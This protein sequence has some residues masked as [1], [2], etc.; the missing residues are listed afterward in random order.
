MKINVTKNSK[1][2]MA[3]SEYLIVLA[4]VA[5]GCICIFGLFGKQIKYTTARAA[6][7]LSG[8]TAVAGNDALKDSDAAAAKKTGMVD[9]NNAGN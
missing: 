7:T 4:V 3:M 9:F 8:E 1:L 2:G 5:L 6:A